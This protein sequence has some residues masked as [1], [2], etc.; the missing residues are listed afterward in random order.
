MTGPAGDN[1]EHSEIHGAVKRKLEH[2]S[3]RDETGRELGHRSAGAAVSPAG[4]T[5]ETGSPDARLDGLIRQYARLVRSVVREIAKDRAASLQEDVE[6]EVFLA[7]W[8]QLDRERSIDHPASYIYRAAVRETVRAVRRAQAADPEFVREPVRLVEKQAARGDPHQ[9]LAAKEQ[10]AAV[11][12]SVAAL[13]PDRA[14]A[15]R[16]HL[17]GMNVAEIMKLYGW[18]YEKARNLVARGMAGLRKALRA[19]GVCE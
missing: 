12:A 18:R 5:P 14:R 10:A 17:L 16:A 8:R 6:Q 15:V 13:A 9:V 2:G 19:R 4:A 7:I 11:A 3:V 1:L